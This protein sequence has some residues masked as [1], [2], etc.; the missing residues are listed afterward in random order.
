MAKNDEIKLDC[1]DSNYKI[2]RKKEKKS[3]SKEKEKEKEKSRHKHIKK[4]DFKSYLAYKEKFLKKFKGNHGLYKVEDKNTE[5]NQREE[6]EAKKEEVEV[7]QEDVK[8]SKGNDF[9]EGEI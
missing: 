6:T 3:K 4:N 8:K 5:E 2:K 9:S 7:K 1:H